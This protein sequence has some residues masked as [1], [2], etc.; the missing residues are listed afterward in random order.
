M[1]KIGKRTSLVTIPIVVVVAFFNY[2]EEEIISF[3]EIPK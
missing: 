1:V 2:G 3:L